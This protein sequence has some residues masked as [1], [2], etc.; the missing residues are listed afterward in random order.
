MEDRI[1]L[2][3]RTRVDIK[4]INESNLPQLQ[5]G[6]TGSKQDKKY[7]LFVVNRIPV[8]TAKPYSESI[9]KR[10]NMLLAKRESEKD[11]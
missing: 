3:L 11:D 4:R 8:E 10:G 7:G 2:K 6:G 5:K 1:L 9:L